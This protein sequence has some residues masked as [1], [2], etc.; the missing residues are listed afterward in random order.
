MGWFQNQKEKNEKYKEQKS[1]TKQLKIDAKIEYRRI[2]KDAGVAFATSS[3]E[4]LG[5]HSDVLT[6]TVGAISVKKN[7]LYFEAS[8]PFRCFIIPTKD[9]IRAE[10]KNDTQIS[11]DV[12][13]V[14]LLA[15]GIFA[16]GAKKK[17]KEEHN[18]LVVKYNSDGIENAVMFE[19]N[20]GIFGQGA[21]VLVGAI[22]KARQEYIKENPIVEEVAVESNLND[23][24]SLI[25]RLS[26]LK[27]Q[28]ILT[29]DEFN[30]K[31]AELLLKI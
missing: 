17:T 29:D 2:S 24:P 10:F 22:M 27:D 9:I 8:L 12:T 25:K 28:G 15:L 14:R 13:M 11:K 1:E 6:K 31:K 19:A 16:F 3:C 18:Y 7:G 26:D 30:L 21:N 20:A 5:G 23:I 4:Y